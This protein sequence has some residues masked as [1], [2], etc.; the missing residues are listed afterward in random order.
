[1]IKDM[2]MTGLGVAIVVVQ[3]SRPH[4]DPL[5]LGMALALTGIPAGVH[6]A[7]LLPA[8]TAGLSS[9]DSSS[10]GSSSAASL[11]HA[12]TGEMTPGHT[13]P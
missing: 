6:F 9:P 2:V 8:P 10:S 5:W 12:A 13:I 11:P 1:M 4:A 3:L 7:A